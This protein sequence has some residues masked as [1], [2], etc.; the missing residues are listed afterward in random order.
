MERDNFYSD[1]IADMKLLD[2]LYNTLLLN[3]NLEQTIKLRPSNEKIIVNIYD[4]EDLTDA[5]KLVKN[6][7]PEWKGSLKQIWNCW[8]DMAMVSWEDKDNLLIDI[9]LETSIKN[10]PKSLT[11]NGCEFKEYTEKSYNYVCNI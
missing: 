7:I 8:G 6:A 10:F 5:R 9:W 2:N 1:R 3:A 4:L 11:K